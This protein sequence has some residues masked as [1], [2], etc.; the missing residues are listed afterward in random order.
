[1]REVTKARTY[2]FQKT[3]AERVLSSLICICESLASSSSILHEIHSYSQNKTEKK[4]TLPACT[5]RFS[6]CLCLT[7]GKPPGPNR[8]KQTRR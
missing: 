6:T 5:A 1:M 2:S 4:L 7:T 3:A 8:A